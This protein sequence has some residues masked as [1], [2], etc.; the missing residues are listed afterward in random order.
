MA[1]Q[2][3]ETAIP[4]VCILVPEVFGDSRGFF[5]E[6]FHAA[7]YRELGLA[8]VFVQD[9]LSHSARGILRGLHYQP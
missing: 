9:N 3:K 7:R 8:D 6:T 2:R 4:G 1:V 5:M